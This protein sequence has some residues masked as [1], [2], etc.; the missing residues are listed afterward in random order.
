MLPF[1][2]VLLKMSKGNSGS[3][4]LSGPPRKPKQ[5]WQAKRVTPHSVRV[6]SHALKLKGPY[7]ILYDIHVYIYI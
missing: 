3:A 7:D 5:V 1:T 6:T 4:G 2:H